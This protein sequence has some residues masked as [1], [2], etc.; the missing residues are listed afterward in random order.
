MSS[1]ISCTLTHPTSHQPLK[2]KHIHHTTT[3]NPILLS[4]ALSTYKSFFIPLKIIIKNF[5][6]PHTALY[7]TKNNYQKSLPTLYPSIFSSTKN[8]HHNIH[9]A[10]WFTKKFTPPSCCYLTQFMPV[11]LFKR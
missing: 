1:D 6:Y 8:S 3:I 5:Y 7:L 10:L 9:N 4:D 11:N 2:K